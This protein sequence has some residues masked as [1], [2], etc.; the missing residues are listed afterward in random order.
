MG[1]PSDSSY[2]DYY[3]NPE[4]SLASS[5]PEPPF[6]EDNLKGYKYFKKISKLLKGLNQRYSHHNR[7]LFYDQYV[8]LILFYYFNPVLTSLRGLQTA[9]GFKKVQKVLGVK[10]TSRTCLSEAGYVFD[11]SLIE[12]LIPK[13]AGK[14]AFVEKDPRLKKIYQEITAV[15]G[16]VLPALPR[17]F[18]ALWMDEDNRAAK[19]HLSLSIDKHVP[20]H[21]SVTEAAVN[22]VTVFRRSL[23]PNRLY[24]LDGGYGHYQLFQEILDAGS[25]FVARLHKNA[26]WETI[27]TQELTSQDLAAGV[28]QDEIVH[29]GSASRRNDCP[30]PLRVVR[31]ESRSRPDSSRPKGKRKKEAAVPQE[32]GVLIIVTDQLDLS[33]EVVA[34]LYKYRWQVEL[35]FRWF[36]CILSCRHFLSLSRKGATMQIYGAL[37]ASLLI[38]LWTGKKPTKRTF[39]VLSFYLSG[40]VDDDELTAHIAGLKSGSK[41]PA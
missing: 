38:S 26:S 16:T 15:D 14:A 20:V 30:M 21:A 19:L 10:P 37:I 33:A 12:P 22:E 39:E 23:A 34:L 4:G 9:S 31:I 41:K 28:I 2:L 25:S 32:P 1:F 29:L 11:P 8:S 24:L 18:W 3:D 5:K 13:L 7:N 17:M 36:K 27:E 35:F 40:W 6:T